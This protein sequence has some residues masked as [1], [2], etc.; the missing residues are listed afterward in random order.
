MD[1]AVSDLRA[2]ALVWGDDDRLH[3]VRPVRE[4]FEPYPG[5]LAPPSARPLPRI[6][7]DRAV[8]ECSAEA[9]AVL[10]RL[11]WSPTGAVR[12]ADRVVSAAAARSPVEELLARELLRPLDS[13]TVLIPRE[14]S[15]RLRG[16]RFTAEPVSSE[17]PEVT[18]RRRDPTLIDR[19]AAG[20]AFGLLHD[21]ELVVQRME[22]EPHR[23]LR[24]GGLGTR[25]LTLVAR[26]LGADP[27]HTT[28]LVECA[29]A[30]GLLAAGPG[31]ALLPT[32]EYDRWVTLDAPIRWRFAAEAWLHADRLFSRAAEPGCARARARG[33]AGGRRRPAGHGA[34]A[35][36]PGRSRAPSWTSTGWPPRSPGTGRGCWT[37]RSMPPR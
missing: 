3:L 11:L 7:I 32:S 13:D 25:E 6:Q 27:A 2:R 21:L 30:A 18:G 19:A 22:E 36:R 37:G 34:R 9:R 1:R 16:R 26:G 15:W 24:T 12:K 20:A 17:P 23:L 35:G 5:G 10:E 28:F 4:A 29:S 33:R 31:L 8:A 14:V